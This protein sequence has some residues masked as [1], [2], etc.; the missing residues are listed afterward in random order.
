MRL[1]GAIQSQTGTSVNPE[2]L[3]NWELDIELPPHPGNGRRRPAP[4]EEPLLPLRRR[5][6]TASAPTDQVDGQQTPCGSQEVPAGQALAGHDPEVARKNDPWADR[7]ESLQRHL[8]RAREFKRRID[9]GDVRNASEAARRAKISRVRVSQL[10]RLLDLAPEIIEDIEDPNGIG[11]VLTEKMLRQVAMVSSRVEQLRRYR[12]LLKMEGATRGQHT[13][14][15]SAWRSRVPRKGIQHQLE[16][17]RRFQALLNSGEVSSLEALGR[18]EGLTGGRIAQLLNLLHLAPVILSIV[19]VPAEQ[20][21][22][23]ISEARLRRIARLQDH[24]QQIWEFRKIA[25]F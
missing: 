14:K 17:A 15:G 18:Q 10:M 1:R 9:I 16:R 13:G 4:P 3:V 20:L 5:G 6:S 7:R 22:V 8:Q 19:D 25:G 24:D 23:E 11:P 2:V 21:P 12:E